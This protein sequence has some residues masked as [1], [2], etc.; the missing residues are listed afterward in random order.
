VI[1]VVDEWGTRMIVLLALAKAEVVTQVRLQL[2]VAWLP[3]LQ[4][5]GIT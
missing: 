3:L 4:L 2:S 5:Y 1:T